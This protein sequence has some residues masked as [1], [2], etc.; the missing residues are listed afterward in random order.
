[1]RA[2]ELNNTPYRGYLGEMDG[3]WLYREETL[4][5]DGW[6]LLVLGLKA[7]PYGPEFSVIGC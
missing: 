1:M 2:G 3:I 6:L 7:E 4:A 5:S